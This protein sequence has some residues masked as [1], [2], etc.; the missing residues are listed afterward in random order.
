MDANTVLTIG[1]S[2]AVLTGAFGAV[3]TPDAGGSIDWQVATLEDTN[4]DGSLSV[5]VNATGNNAYNQPISDIVVL[6]VL[7]SESHAVVNRTH[8]FYD[9]EIQP[10]TWAQ[11]P[12][13]TVRFPAFDANQTDHVRVLIRHEL[14][15]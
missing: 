4:A 15:G 6:I 5:T 12:D 8:L 14:S 13:K 7:H 3:A 11:L 1:L 2:I 9:A 10:D